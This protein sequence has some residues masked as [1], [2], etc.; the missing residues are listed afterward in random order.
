[1]VI[2]NRKLDMCIHK[3]FSTSHYEHF[4]EKI[5]TDTT[6]LTTFKIMSH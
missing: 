5:V 1:M 2:I 6:D 3:T 4:A